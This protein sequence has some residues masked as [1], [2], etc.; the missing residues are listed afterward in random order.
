MYIP[1]KMQ[2]NKFEAVSLPSPKSWF[3]RTGEVA[4]PEKDFSGEDVVPEPM[5]K[6]DSIADYEQYAAEMARLAELEQKNAV[7]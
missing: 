6:V 7:K 1:E 3:A 4:P 5:R 2:I